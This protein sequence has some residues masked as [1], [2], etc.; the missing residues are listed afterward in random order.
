MSKN[1]GYFDVIAEP[2]VRSAPPVTL[3]LP[4]LF[5][6][7]RATASM[8]PESFFHVALKVLERGDADD[9]EGATAVTHAALEVA[10]KRVYLFDRAPY[11]AAGLVDE[12]PLGF[13]HVGFVVDDVE[14]AAKDLSGAGVEFVM[15]PSVFGDLKIAFVADPAGVRIELLEH[16]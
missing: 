15:E 6:S 9:G 2:L 1:S 5:F 16:R 11:E 7:A 3:G 12:L 8:D 4:N 10:D 13:L 14:A